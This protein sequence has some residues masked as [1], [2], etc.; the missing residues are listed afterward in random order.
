MEYSEF[1]EI[2]EP[3]F[4]NPIEGTQEEV[5]QHLDN[6]LWVIAGPGSGKT[7][8][9]V[10]RTL[11][12]IY[13]DDIPPKSIIITT[14]TKKAAK[15]LMD[16][17]LGYLPAIYSR[18][19]E[20][21]R[22]I[23]IHQ[24]RIGT[25]HSLCTDIMQEYKFPQFENFRILDEIEQIFFIYDHSILVNERSNRF[26]SLWNFFNFLLGNRQ[27][28]FFKTKAAVKLL[29]RIT[30]DRVDLDRL[31][32]T[33]P[34]MELL[35]EVYEDYRNKLERFRRCDYS[36]LQQ[37]FL[38]F[39]ESDLGR[40]FLSGD[41]SG[42]HPGIRYVMVDEYQ[43][44]N[45]IQE[46]I[47]LNL[48]ESTHN[49]CVVGDDDQALYRFRGGTVDCMITFDQACARN[50]GISPEVVINNRKFLNKN[51]RSHA[52]IVSFFDNY[53]NSFP[54]MHAEGA[55]VQAK[56]N[57]EPYSSITG[58]YPPVA[59]IMGQ[60][61]EITARNFAHFVRGLIDNHIIEDPSQC[62]LLMRSVKENSRNAGPFMRALLDQEIAVYNPR[63]KSFLFQEE[64]QLA[65]GSLIKIL[66]P[67]LNAL[68]STSPSIQ[69]LVRDWIKFYDLYIR[70]HPEAGQL[71]LYVNESIRRIPL[72]YEMNTWMNLTILEIFYRI[73]AHDPFKQWQ[74]DPERTYRLGQITKIIE[75]YSSI[76]Y[77]DRVGSNRG[78]LKR[79]S[80]REEGFSFRWRRKF[81]YELIGYLSSEGM[82]DPE[83]EEIICP[84]GRL[85]IMTV[86]QA[87]GLQFPFV[88]V[89]GLNDQ[90]RVDST[91]QLENTFLP[92]RLNNSLV[93]LTPEQKAAQDLVRFYFVAYSRPQ[94]GL[95]HVIPKAHQKNRFGYP[96]QDNKDYF[97]EMNTSGGD[98][99]DRA[100]LR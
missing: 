39:L 14:F 15:N 36:Y 52:G 38:T 4:G 94:Y 64:V 16:R 99:Y 61:I 34:E 43:D 20:M 82:N 92:F 81:Y 68:A 47:Y 79:S 86:H 55:R 62:V 22:E 67:Q 6:P 100:T 9:L 69:N 7:E 74:D 25:L 12:L 56:P 46:Q 45:P 77:P 76:P 65:L 87:K 23:D 29:N 83:D 13:V 58:T 90:P 26:D 31:R 95:I 57:L 3:I 88:F 85:P 60:T 51:Y 50:W 21:E 24:L 27:G 5:I 30:E 19:P 96:N 78:Q 32:E 1:K 17:I 97:R 91:I 84:V 80:M 37:K 89:Y 10:L 71:D 35:V 66:D 93:T 42:I 54:V 28:K 48:A 2:I 49:L 63:S 33:S 53:I 18:F 73:I 98:L 72:D 11:K 8:V 75:S 44:T 70:N 40:L 41:G 59:Y